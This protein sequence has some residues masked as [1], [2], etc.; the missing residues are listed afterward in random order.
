MISSTVTED[1]KERRVVRAR[2]PRS[3]PP[4]STEPRPA[5]PQTPKIVAAGSGKF[6]RTLPPGVESALHALGRLKRDEVAA[7]TFGEI[8]ITVEH[9]YG[10]VVLVLPD[11]TRATATPE[12][13][14]QLA[15]LLLGASTPRR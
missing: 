6:G 2:P 13:A 9:R 10:L 4:P 5:E 8:T 12:Q 14:E 11:G 1:D 7:V 15:K 3:E